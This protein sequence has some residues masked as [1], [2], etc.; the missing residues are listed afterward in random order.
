MKV[1]NIKAKVA[2]KVA[3]GKAKVAAKCGKAAKAVAVLFALAFV[4]GCQNPAQRSI[5]IETNVYAYD[6]SNITF[7]GSGDVGSAA[8]SNETGVN[9]AG[10]VASPTNDIKPD[11]DVSVPVNKANAG[12]SGA[13]MGALENVLGAGAD[14]VAGKIKGG[15]DKAAAT[16]QAA[17]QS[18]AQP[19]QATQSAATCPGGNCAPGACT[20]GSCSTCTDC[21][22]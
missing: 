21:Q 12:T 4:F 22:R 16:T 20:D 6:K 19:A 14:W 9:D 15:D 3:K 17:T 18:A 13:T 1:K 7:G 5:T 2:A 8:Q 10:M 11:I